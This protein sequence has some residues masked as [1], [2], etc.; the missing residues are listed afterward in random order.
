MHKEIEI[1]NKISF[2]NTIKIA[3]FD[4]AKRYTKP[5][6]HNKYLEIVFFSKGSGFHYLDSKP[7][8]ITTPI[9]FFI[10]KNQ[11]H[12]WE[13]DSIPE[14]FVFIIKESFLENLVD[15]TILFQLQKIKT[16]NEVHIDENDEIIPSLFKMLTSEM[17][18]HPVNFEVI[19]SGIKAILSKIIQYSQTVLTVS[20]PSIEQQFLQLLSENLVNNVAFYAEKLHT[21]S[22]NLNA[23]CQ[24]SFQK[25][26]SEVVA[27][28][29]VKEIKRK[30]L[31]TS[32]NISDI[33]FDL[34]F[35][36]T[37]NFTKFFK[38]HTKTTPL[39]FK[40]TAVL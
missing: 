21:S 4:V 5:H 29:I 2:E 28:W 16:L 9:L 13:I 11:V 27:D 14:G 8:E 30:L 26:A 23:I 1:K 19:E 12:H 17:K 7:F 32:K 31:Y 37:S 34:N 35:K 25:S 36:D 33:A 10:H 24:K 20:Q 3:P 38:R 15:N 18:Q 22:Q 39:Q 6:V 40:K